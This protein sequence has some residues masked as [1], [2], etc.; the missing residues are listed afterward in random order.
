[1]VEVKHNLIARRQKLREGMSLH[2][3]ELLS[4]KRYVEEYLATEPEGAEEIRQILRKI[5]YMTDLSG[6]GV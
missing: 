6:T 3:E 2:L 4:E 1:M 5:E